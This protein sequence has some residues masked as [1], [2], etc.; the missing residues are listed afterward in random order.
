MS[1]GLLD[2]TFFVDVWRGGDDSSNKL[3]DSI[4]SGQLAAA[5]SPVTAYELWVGQR[6]SR[7]EEI[8]YESVFSILESTA[9]EVEDAKQASEWLRGMADRSELIFRDALIA[10]VAVRRHEPVITRNVGDFRRFPGV[11]VETY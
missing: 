2:T 9:I 3:L 1:D 10:A 4:R 7:E 8:F 5:Y 6:F 11:S